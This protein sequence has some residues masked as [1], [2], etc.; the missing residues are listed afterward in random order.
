MNRTVYGGGGREVKEV[1][2]IK[3]VG[4]AQ[5]RKLLVEGT[6][7]EVPLTAR[8]GVDTVESRDRV[9][10]LG[11]A[12]PRTEETKVA[13]IDGLAETRGEHVRSGE[14]LNSR[15]QL[16]VEWDEGGQTLQAKG[17]TVDISPKGCLAIVEQELPVGQKL[18]I[19]NG[20]SGKSASATLIW[21]GHEGRKGWELGLE[22]EGMQEDF[23]GLE[24]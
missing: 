23:W 17:Y 7:A 19:V 8:S 14:R 18:R 12:V 1:K 15:V 13:R 24:Y 16:T 9:C 3:E 21:R 22:L 6:V 2:E 20:L 4:Q 11:C 5:D 10:L